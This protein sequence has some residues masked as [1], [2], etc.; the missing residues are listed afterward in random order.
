MPLSWFQW[1]Y[2]TSQSSSFERGNLKPQDLKAAQEI[3]WRLNPLVLNEA[4]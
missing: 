3:L 2:L 4:I 1:T